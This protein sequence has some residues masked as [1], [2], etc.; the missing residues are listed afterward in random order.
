MIQGCWYLRR[1]TDRWFLSKNSTTR[2]KDSKVGT[3]RVCC[4]IVRSLLQTLRV[5]IYTLVLTRL[6]VDHEDNIYCLNQCPGANV[7]LAPVI[8]SFL[9]YIQAT[10]SRILKCFL[11]QA[12]NSPSAEWWRAPDRMHLYRML[13][14]KFPVE[15][16]FF[17]KL[18]PQ[19][20]LFPVPIFGVNI[21]P[22]NYGIKSDFILELTIN[23]Q[24]L[25]AESVQHPFFP[26]S[27]RWSFRPDPNPSSSI[28]Q[29]Q[30]FKWRTK[31]RLFR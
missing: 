9:P 12:Q 17:T 6:L 19:V 16:C 25:Q 26:P 13:W 24:H 4:E 23:A 30:I 5:H 2:V 8:N 21:C 29:A 10:S 1:S 3:G 18:G 27:N 22:F 15:W 14:G 31:T 20:S 28:F 11:F 7:R